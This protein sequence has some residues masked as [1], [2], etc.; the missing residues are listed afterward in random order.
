MFQHS[1]QKQCHILPLTKK[2]KNRS[3]LFGKFGW[4]CQLTKILHSNNSWSIGQKKLL[5][6]AEKNIKTYKHA[7]ANFVNPQNI[8]SKHAEHLIPIKPT[9]WLLI[10]KGFWGKSHVRRQ[11]IGKGRIQWLPQCHFWYEMLKYCW[12]LA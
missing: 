10:N 6:K 12:I 11:N 3:T 5:L 8:F 1:L 4:P 2:P 9:S 7:A